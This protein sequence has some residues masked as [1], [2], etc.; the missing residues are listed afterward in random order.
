M[1]YSHWIQKAIQNKNKLLKESRESSTITKKQI[2][3]HSMISIRELYKAQKWDH[4]IKL[5]K[6]T[7]GLFE[8]YDCIKVHK[9]VIKL[10]ESV[11]IN[12]GDAHD[13]DYIGTIKQIIS[14]KEPTTLKLICLCRVQWY[15]RKSEIIKSH[16]KSNEWISEQELF[17]TKHEDYILAETV[18]HS[19]QIFTCKE[20]V[21][22]DEIESTIYF[23]RLS[24]DM[25]K[26]Q[27]QGLEKLQKFCLCQQPVNPDRKYIQCDSCHQWYHLEC[28]GLKEEEL[29]DSEFFCKLCL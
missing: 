9:K 7:K 28:V 21:N 10:E 27:F 15:M 26:K 17:E 20:Y 24:W 1:N 22:L 12:S 25:E 18:I 5:A 4:L 29:N 11:L 8:E 3:K 6:Q 14:I 23:N 2:S 13:E 19:C 16:P